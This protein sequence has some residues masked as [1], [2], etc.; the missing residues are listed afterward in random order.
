MGSK[1]KQEKGPS[2]NEK[3]VPMV[4]GTIFKTHT[5]FKVQ[6]PIFLCSHLFSRNFRLINRESTNLLICLIFSNDKISKKG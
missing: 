5:V 4:K 1:D 6:T 2:F 3:S